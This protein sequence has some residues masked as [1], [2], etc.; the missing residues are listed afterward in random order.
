MRMWRGV[1]SQS[2]A[3]T[4]AHTV[5]HTTV[6]FA[7]EETGGATNGNAYYVIPTTMRAE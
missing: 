7:S 4:L 6:A 3:T 2:A 1:E 5:V